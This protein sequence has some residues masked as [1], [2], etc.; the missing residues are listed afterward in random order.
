[1]ADDD[2]R[3]RAVEISTAEYRVLLIEIQKDIQALV[4][5]QKDL[6]VTLRTVALA[7]G[8]AAMAFTGLAV[9]IATQL[10]S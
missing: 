7:V 4:Q 5:V 8:A 2:E 9:T 10:P 3:L 6:K 1:M